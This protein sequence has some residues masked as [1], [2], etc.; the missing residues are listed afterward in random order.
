[1]C[2]SGPIFLKD[3]KWRG[4]LHVCNWDIPYTC[5]LFPF[6]MRCFS[7]IHVIEAFTWN[8]AIRRFQECQKVRCLHCLASRFP[9]P[10]SIQSLFFTYGRL[11]LSL[12][13][14]RSSSGL[15]GA[16]HAYQIIPASPG[17]FTISGLQY[18][19]YSEACNDGA[20]TVVEYLAGNSYKSH[21]LADQ[22]DTKSILRDRGLTQCFSNGF[23]LCAE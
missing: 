8:A 5:L 16:L 12:S 15:L 22:T 10:L 17:R 20:R 18:W 9:P 6:R 14:Q 21:S 23:S 13:T 7:A 1:M 4:C 2:T 11:G 19:P 3:F